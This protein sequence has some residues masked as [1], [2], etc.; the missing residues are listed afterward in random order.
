MREWQD[1]EWQDKAE[2][3]EAEVERLTARVAGLQGMLEDAQEDKK[4]AQQ[5]LS[6]LADEMIYEGNSVG[7]IYTKMHCYG[8]QLRPAYDALRTLGWDGTACHDNSERAA[9]IKT[10]AANLVARLAKAEGVLQDIEIKLMDH[11]VA[12]EG[13]VDS[14]AYGCIEDIIAYLTEQGAETQE[15]TP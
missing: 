2:R 12:V 13:D 8:D 7:Y 4:Q 5:D 1:R 3:A 11:F 6:D 10:W 15:K 9:S 14:V